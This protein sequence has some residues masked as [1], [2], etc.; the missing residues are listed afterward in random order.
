MVSSSLT[1]ISSAL[2]GSKV[3]V[4]TLEVVATCAERER[5]NKKRRSDDFINHYPLEPDEEH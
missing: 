5:E 1:W 4:S 3:E 2:S